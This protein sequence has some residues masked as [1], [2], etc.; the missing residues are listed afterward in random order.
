MYIDQAVLGPV[1]GIDE[2]GF[3]IPE[4]QRNITLY[5]SDGEV[6]ARQRINDSQKVAESAIR[7]NGY[8]HYGDW[9]FGVV[10][11][12]KLS[13]IQRSWPWIVGSAVVVLIFA[14]C[15]GA[16]SGSSG[17]DDDTY[18]PDEYGA[19]NI[20]EEAVKD[21]L[22]APS[23]AKFSDVQATGAGGSWTVTGLVEAEN[24]FG[25]TV[26]NRYT[27]DATYTSSDDMWRGVAHLSE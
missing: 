27:C 24:G 16:F 17:A 21:R 14:S 19:Q 25:G 3:A 8:K 23:T 26:G 10:Q 6:I 5:G 20:C 4:G 7:A 22:R 18:H 1:G 15:S 11:I 9:H 2:G 13:W 12:R